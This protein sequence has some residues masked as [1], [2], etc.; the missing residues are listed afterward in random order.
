MRKF[1]LLLK[2]GQIIQDSTILSLIK[3]DPELEYD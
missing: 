3:D 2:E 1:L